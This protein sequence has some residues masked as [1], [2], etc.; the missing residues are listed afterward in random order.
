MIQFGRISCDIFGNAAIV[1]EETAGA[2]VF[3]QIRRVENEGLFE[4]QIIQNGGGIVGDEQIQNGQEPFGRDGTVGA[5]AVIC[6]HGIVMGMVLDQNQP[7]LAQILLQLH[8]L[9]VAQS[10]R[11]SGLSP[12]CGSPKQDLLTVGLRILGIERFAAVLDPF[13]VEKHIGAADTQSLNHAFFLAHGLGQQRYIGRRTGGDQRIVFKNVTFVVTGDIIICGI[14]DFF[15]GAGEVAQL[16]N[17]GVAVQGGGRYRQ[18]RIADKNVL[19]LC[20]QIHK[21]D[22]VKQALDAAFVGVI[23]KMANGI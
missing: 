5:A 20:Q 10:I 22:G 17:F 23:M 19:C 4:G 11:R 16:H 9:P 2:F 7:I 12:E 13:P 21:R 1:D 8:E 6:S 14:A 15:E 3:I 18:E